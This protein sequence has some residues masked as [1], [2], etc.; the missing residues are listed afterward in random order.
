MDFD[1]AL[2][3]WVKLLEEMWTKHCAINF[4]NLKPTKIE[5]MPG[6]KYIKVVRFDSRSVYCFIDKANGN[7]LKPASWKA[8]EPKKIPRGN[9]FNNNPLEGCGVYSVDYLR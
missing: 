9:I 6:N 3:N 4:P 8:P 2:Q 1:S 7:I 5:L